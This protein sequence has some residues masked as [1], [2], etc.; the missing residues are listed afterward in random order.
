MPLRNKLRFYQMADLYTHRY[1][2]MRERSI[3]HLVPVS[4]TPHHQAIQLDPLHLYITSPKINGFR[5]NL[6]FGGDAEETLDGHW[7][8]L[9]GCFK[10]SNRQIFLPAKGHRLIA[11]V[12]W[13]MMDKYPPLRDQEAQF[14]ENTDTWNRWLRKPWTPMDR[15]LLEDNEALEVVGRR[16][17]S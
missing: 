12:V 10:N 4:C 14:F 11:H 6:R 8:E 1:L 17:S 9:D 3:E 15:H 5:S 7:K 2:L 16:R 13:K